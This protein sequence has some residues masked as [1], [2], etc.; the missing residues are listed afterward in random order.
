MKI[1]RHT[2]FLAALATGAML[3]LPSCVAENWDDCPP[4]LDMRLLIRTDHEHIYET[5]GYDEEHGRR[6]TRTP[7]EEWYAIDSV[8]VYVFDQADRFVKLWGGGRYTIGEDYE[9]PLAELDLPEGL[10]SF[11]VWTN[12]GLGHCYVCNV[13]E[14]R[15]GDHIDDFWLR[16]VVP[17]DGSMDETLEH[18]HFGRIDNV[19][20]SHNSLQKE[21]VIVIDPGIHRLHFAVSSGIAENIDAGHRYEMTIRDCNSLHDFRNRH[22][23]G[24]EE[25][26]YVYPMTIVPFGETRAHGD[27]VTAS[28]DLLQIHDETGTIVEITDKSTDSTIYSTDLVEMIEMVYSANGQQVDFEH[29]LEFDIDIHVVSHIRINFNINGWKYALNGSILGN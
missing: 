19:Y 29:T 6:T 4:E 27:V 14:R 20:V 26:N 11:I 2:G 28:A 21:H 16:T 10:Y 25:H 1:F 3:L 8:S 18:R 9:I 13:L 15:P 23:D 12:R 24:E 17:V 5:R 22:I 7:V